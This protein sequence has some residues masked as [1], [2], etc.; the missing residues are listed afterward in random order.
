MAHLVIQLSAACEKPTIVVKKRRAEET[1]ILLQ[2]LHV[3][4]EHFFEN[5]KHI[6]LVHE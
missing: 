2:T 4:L 3:I 5:F 6:L 1:P